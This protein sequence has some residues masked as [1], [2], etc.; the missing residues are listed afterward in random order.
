MQVFHKH[1]MQIKGKD[2]GFNILMRISLLPVYCTIQWQ[3]P[4]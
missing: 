2:K 3:K 1:D 4:W